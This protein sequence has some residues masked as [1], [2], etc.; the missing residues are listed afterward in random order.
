MKEIRIAEGKVAF[1]P[2]SNGDT[3]SAVTSES[4]LTSGWSRELL[5]ILWPATK[6]QPSKN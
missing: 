5:E 3:I 4:L 1:E 2:D 6:R